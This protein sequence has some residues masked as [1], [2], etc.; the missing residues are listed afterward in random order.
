MKLSFISRMQGEEIEKTPNKKLHHADA[1]SF[2]DGKVTKT[3][4][5]FEIGSI[6]KSDRFTK[7]R[8]SGKIT[9]KQGKT[10]FSGEISKTREAKTADTISAAVF[11]ALLATFTGILGFLFS[12]K[13][14][15][16]A[17]FAA[18]F[19]LV[20]ILINMG[21]DRKEFK[22]TV[23]FFKQY[24]KKVF[25]AEVEEDPTAKRKK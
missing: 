16:A 15:Y 19:A 18:V 2:L 17:I 14:L 25:R 12:G 23:S 7:Y 22:G 11:A 8:Y 5:L 1:K 13:L 24:M 9:E 21:T 3:T 10:L 4:F 20:G 6:T